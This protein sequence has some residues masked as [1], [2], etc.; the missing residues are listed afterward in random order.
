MT[1]HKENPACP[2]FSRTL[3]SQAAGFRV[4]TVEGTRPVVEKVVPVTPR[5]SLAKLAQ[6]GDQF[7]MVRLLDVLDNFLLMTTGV[8]AEEVDK[9][10][11]VT[12]DKVDG[13]LFQALGLQH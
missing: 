10:M 5:L 8:S 1:R 11:G 3:L 2:L 12:R 13:P 9:A 4:L 6:L 7:E